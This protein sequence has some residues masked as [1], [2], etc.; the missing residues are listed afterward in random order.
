MKN[1]SEVKN[2][3]EEWTEQ[4]W[5]ATPLPGGGVT[6][7]GKTYSYHTSVK[8][9]KSEEGRVKNSSEVKSEER[10]VKNTSVS[11]SSET[12]DVKTT[13]KRSPNE[14]L[15]ILCIWLIGIVIIVYIGYW[16]ARRNN[17]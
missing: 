16:I 12:N 6:V 17:K 5:I 1:S 14:V 9:V 2:S 11:K 3:C 10:S 8:E 13:F 4:V 15:T 7:T